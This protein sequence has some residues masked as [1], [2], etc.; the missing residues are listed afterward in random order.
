MPENPRSLNSTLEASLASEP[1]WRTW[2]GVVVFLPSSLV[3]YFLYLI[4]NTL[5]TAVTTSVVCGSAA[6]SSVLA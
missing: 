3:S 4:P 6:A 2:Y 1:Y 5:L